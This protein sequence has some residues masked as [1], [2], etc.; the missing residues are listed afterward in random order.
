M[1]RATPP[2]TDLAPAAHPDATRPSPAAAGGEQDA[3]SAQQ[4]A[5]ARLV[6]VGVLARAALDDPGVAWRGD[7]TEEEL[8]R[9]EAAG[10]RARQQLVA[11]N[12]GLVGSV[13]AR[14]AGT[15][16]AVADLFQEGCVGL[17][18]AVERFDHRRGVRFSTYASYW[19]RACV[20]AAAT[21]F[22]GAVTVPA[23]RGEQLRVVRGVEG[24]LV[25][26]L[27]REP[28]TAEVAAAL[29][30]GERWTAGLLA[31]R[32]SWSLDD[33]DDRALERVADLDRRPEPGRDDE[34]RVWAERLLGS[35]DDFDRRVLELRFGFRGEEPTS[36]S[37]A[38]RVLGVPVG[39]VRRAEV[40]AL[41]LL[42]AR[43]PHGVLSGAVA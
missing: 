39:R 32:P 17:I 34:G 2:A 13:A 19:I 5:W 25:Q 15:G 21:R 3:R 29:G 27:A 1:T 41:E 7:A 42:R 24:S 40:R 22:S 6:E 28:T 35:L 43:C 9:L 26:H 18:V 11:G 8:R 10:A 36:L 31:Q 33:V 12:L 38:A 4:D 30:R 16:A 37:G 23:H 14:Y 20:S